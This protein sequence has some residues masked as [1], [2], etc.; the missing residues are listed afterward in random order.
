[1]SNYIF[2]PGPTAAGFAD[3]LADRARAGV[4]VSVLL[5]AWGSTAK[6]RDL[7]AGMKQAGVNF[8]WF[9]TPRWYQAQ[10]FNYRMHRRILVIDGA[11]AFTGGFG[12]A[13]KWTGDAENSRHW[14]D[15]HLGIEGLA[16]PGL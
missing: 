5:D 16:R 6:N 4:D 12:I 7:V 3:A 11:T 2:W 8:A 9:R 14:R 15:T 1:L 10:R 13:E